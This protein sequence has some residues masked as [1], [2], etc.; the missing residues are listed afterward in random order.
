MSDEK[1]R[2]PRDAIPHIEPAGNNI[3]IIRPTSN[4]KQLTH[5]YGF[6]RGKPNSKFVCGQAESEPKFP[7]EKPLVRYEAIEPLEENISSSSSIE[8]LP[9]NIVYS[10]GTYDEKFDDTESLEEHRGKVHKG[11]VGI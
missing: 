3:I 10:C 5:G 11:P 1:Y 4:E 2:I 7:S 6:A 8:G 9:K